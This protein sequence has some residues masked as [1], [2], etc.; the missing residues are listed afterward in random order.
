MMEEIVVD[1]PRDLFRTGSNT[2]RLESDGG[3]RDYLLLGR[4][5]L[6]ETE[7]RDLEVSRCPS[8]VRLGEEFAIELSARRTLRGVRA[9]LPDG[10]RALTELPAELGAG[11]YRLRVRAEQPLADAGS[12]SAPTG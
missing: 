6:E 11:D 12:A 3:Q 8:W 9:Q 7:R 5:F 1:L 10:L 2:L 4:V